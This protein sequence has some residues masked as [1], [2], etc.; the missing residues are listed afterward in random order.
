MRAIMSDLEPSLPLQVPAN[1]SHSRDMS[2]WKVCGQG[3]M[4]SLR[5]VVS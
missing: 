4:R 1:G 2:R 3:I 5:L